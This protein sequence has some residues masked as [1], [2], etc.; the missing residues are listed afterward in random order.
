[1]LPVRVCRH[2]DLEWLGTHECRCRECG[3]FGRWFDGF[4][5]WQRRIG[6]AAVGSTTELAEPPASVAM[7]RHAMVG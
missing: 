5:V 4:V 2:W 6:H 3:R 1:M 7:V